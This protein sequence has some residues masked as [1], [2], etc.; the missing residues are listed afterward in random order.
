MILA[1]ANPQKKAI[2]NTVNENKPVRQSRGQ[3]K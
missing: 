3:V 2:L 1:L